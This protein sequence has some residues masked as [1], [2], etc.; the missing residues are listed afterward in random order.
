[1]Y[2]QCTVFFLD[3]VKYDIHEYN[4]FLIKCRKIIL[5]INLLKKK[6]I[7]IIVIAKIQ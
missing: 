1:M 2:V 4:F 3:F 5:V 6:I 7:L